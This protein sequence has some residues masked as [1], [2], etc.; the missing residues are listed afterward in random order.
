MP[1]SLVSFAALAALAAT[2]A[3]PPNFHKDVLPILQQRCQQCHRP[4]E[5]SPMSLITYAGTR[6]WAKS[7]REAVITRKMPPW[8][9]DPKYGHFANDRSLSQTEIETL[10]AWVDAGTPAGDPKDAPSPRTWPQGW[11]IGTPDAVF[12]MTA[13]FPIPA[14]GSIDYQYIILPTH[15]S[16]DKWI[17][18]VEVRPSDPRVVHHAVVYI[19]E[20]ASKWLQGQPDRRAFSVPLSKGFTTSDILMVYTPGNSFDLWKSGMAKKIKAGSD[21]VLQMHYTANG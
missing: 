3:T 12:E 17:Q 16:G 11:T 19:R 21:L 8:F 2:A 18:K 15:F 5:I 6:P 20:P 9:A 4:G 13:P 10:V 7:I 1:R 14:K